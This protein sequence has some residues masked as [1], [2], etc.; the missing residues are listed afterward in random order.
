MRRLA[1]TLALRDVCKVSKPVATGVALGLTFALGAGK[2]F[3]DHG[4]SG[5]WQPEDWACNV[6]PLTIA[7][8]MIVKFGK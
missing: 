5:K 8:V 1:L 6:I 4:K 3:Y 7:A 2:E